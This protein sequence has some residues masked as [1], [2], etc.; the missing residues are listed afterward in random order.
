MSD[1]D[2]INHFDWCWKTLLDNFAKENIRIKHGGRHKDYFQEFFRDTFYSQ[3]DTKVRSTIPQFLSDLF[4][5]T[6]PFTKSDLDIITELY[7]CLEK[8]IEN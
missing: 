6:K 3:V 5:M 7:K 4:T 1:D 8:N 2:K